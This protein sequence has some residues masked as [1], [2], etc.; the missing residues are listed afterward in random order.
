MNKAQKLGFKDDKH[1]GPCSVYGSILNSPLDR[2][3]LPMDAA[4][5]RGFCSVA[6]S[7]GFE[8]EECA[9]PQ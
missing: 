2:L 7:A 9:E 8:G 4:S 6:N 1:A 5:D 3:A